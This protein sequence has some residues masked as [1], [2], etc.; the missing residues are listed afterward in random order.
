[1]SPGNSGVKAAEDAYLLGAMCSRARLHGVVRGNGGAL[2]HAETGTLDR[3]ILVHS[4]VVVAARP[5]HL[6]LVLLLSRPC[7][8]GEA[9]SRV[10]GSLLRRPQQGRDVVA[11]GSCRENEKGEVYNV[12]SS[13]V[14]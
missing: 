12:G 11:V 3:L 4:G 5:R 7:R 10:L 14:E 8:H 1:M 2:T 13:G 6:H 9:R